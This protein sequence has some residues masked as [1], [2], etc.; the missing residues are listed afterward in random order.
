[1]P[2]NL[3]IID[4]G[5]SLDQY[6]KPV[7][8]N[9]GKYKGQI[10]DVN[11]NKSAKG[12]NYYAIQF[13]IPPEEYQGEQSDDLADSYPDGVTLTYNRVLVPRGPNDGNAIYRIRRLYQAMGLKMKT[14][15]IDPNEWM[16][17]EVL[18][19]TGVDEWEG[20]PRAQI[21]GIE[22]SDERGSRVTSSEEDEE[23][24]PKRRG[25]PAAKR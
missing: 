17:Q 13:I 11:V 18:V 7:V 5:K 6:E 22:V 4:L 19:R 12:N 24:T 2:K 21:V 20:E 8:L 3:S 25:R 23:E 9:A 1:M 16:G 15:E 10:T 14:S